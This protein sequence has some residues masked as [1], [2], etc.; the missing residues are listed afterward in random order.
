MSLCVY[1]CVFLSVGTRGG[2][3]RICVYIPVSMSVFVCLGGGGGTVG[4]CL[5]V[6]EVEMTWDITL[7]QSPSP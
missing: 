2:V 5:C 4:A 1:A 7:R 3:V 6:C